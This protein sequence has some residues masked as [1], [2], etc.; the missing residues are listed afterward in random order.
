M[1]LTTP[2]SDARLDRPRVIQ[3][4]P[5]AETIDVA[6]ARAPVGE[7]APCLPA[8]T[9]VWYLL[10]PLRS[11]T[12]I[13]DLAGS[14]PD[15]PVVRVYRRP[16]SAAAEPEFLGCASPVW[17]G[18]HSLELPVLDDDEL[19]AQIG[20]SESRWGTIVVRAELRI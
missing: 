20:T 11:G 9:S 5:F 4:L 12:L 18:R 13:V 3:D 14:T 17:N 2:T 8:A 15:D 19:L 1:I 6:D 10:G 7:P 16:R